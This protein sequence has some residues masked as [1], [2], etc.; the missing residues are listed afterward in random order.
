[1]SWIT[2]IFEII[3]VPLMIGCVVGAA[4]SKHYTKI[5]VLQIIQY[6]LIGLQMMLAIGWMTFRIFY[7]M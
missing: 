6:V 7:H 1:M 2:I 4:K 3:A 5:H